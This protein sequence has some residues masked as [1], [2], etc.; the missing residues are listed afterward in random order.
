VS[1]LQEARDCRRIARQQ[2]ACVER[3]G[4]RLAVGTGEELRPADLSDPPEKSIVQDTP[5]R[6]RPPIFARDPHQVSERHAVVD[7]QTPGGA[8]PLVECGPR[9]ARQ[10]FGRA[11]VLPREAFGESLGHVTSTTY[12]PM[13]D[14]NIALALVQGGPERE[15]Q[16]LYVSSPVAGTNIRVRVVAPAFF[17]PDGSRAHA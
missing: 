15:G 4:K 14:A 7:P 8:K 2:A 1:R 16:T 11:T 3:V 17:D 12:S 13:L 10:G 6:N 9:R 5:D